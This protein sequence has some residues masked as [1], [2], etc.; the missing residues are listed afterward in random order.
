MSLT[1]EQANALLTEKPALFNIEEIA[2]RGVPTRVW[3]AAPPSLRT[4]LDISRSHGAKDY[5]V[6]EDER[7]TF[8]EH[9][10][11]VAALATRMVEDLGIQKGDRVALAMR[12][13]PE[14]PMV[15]WATVSIGA[16]IVPLNAWWTGDELEFG[17]A[18][19][20]ARVLFCDAERLERI[21]PHLD[22]LPALER[23]IVARGPANLPTGVLDFQAFRGDLPEKAVLPKAT[24]APDDD[25]TIFYTSGTTGKP[26]GALGTHR[27]VCQNLISGAFVRMRASVLRGEDPAAGMQMVGPSMLLSVPLFHVT[28]CHGFL[29]G[30]TL[31]GGKLVMMYKWD[32]QRA[33]E[34]I[35]A[36]RISTFGGVPSMVWQVLEHP[37]LPNHD[38]SC[39][40]NIAY[41]GAP[42]APELLK[43]IRQ[44]FP[45]VDPGNGYGMTETSALCTSNSAE[46]YHRRPDSVGCP[47]PVTEIKIVGADGSELPRGQ[48]GELMVKGP[49]VIKG[50]WNRPEA[51]ASTFT[52]GWLHTGDLACRTPE[53]YYKITGRLKDMI[54]R[55]GENIYPKELEEFLYTCPKVKDVQVI[56]V[57]DEAMGE[58][59]MACVVLKEGQTAT[60][61]EL[62]K[63]CKAKLAKHKC[64]RYIDFVD[65]FPMNVA[66]KI[67]KYKMRE[68]AI[69][70]LG[71]TKAAKIKT[72]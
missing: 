25:A 63:F 66:G 69:Q 48:V 17:L 13:L 58:E 56:G 2:I 72:A 32:A 39:V 31:A 23:I 34:L 27:N 70:K 51:N 54:I 59:V 62:K 11:A 50:Y 6:Y 9:Y 20:G 35:E 55:G 43:R 28:G 37:D 46:E 4:V 8:A 52:E 16:V 3:K 65:G 29:I 40:T 41:G 60:E 47:A 18:D 22:R 5:L 10:R 42:A 38:L 33:I 26:K 67:L 49:N 15:F 21:A 36:E 68:D 61:D 12:N 1:I 71:L 57:P 14:W 24:I 19:S 7:W 53:G 30:M 64:P 45:K 44:T